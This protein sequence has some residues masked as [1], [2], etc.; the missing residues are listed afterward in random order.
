VKRAAW[1]FVAL[2]TLAPPVVADD[3]EQAKALFLA[4][5]AAYDKHDY[6]A[7]I[8]AFEGAERA[9]PR[10]PI[11]FSLAQAHRRQ[12]YVDGNAEHQHTAI[13]LFREY[14]KAVPSGGRHEDAMRALQELGALAPQHEGTSISINSSGTPNARVALDGAAA[15]DAPLIGSVS[16][17]KHHAVISADGFASEE[18]DVVAVDGNIVA[19]DV[20]L[21]EKLAHVTISGR[22]GA[23]VIVD[24]RPMGETPFAAPLELSPGTHVI[25]ISK[26]GFEGYVRDLDLARGESRRIDA[27]LP[28]SK[29]RVIATGLLITSAVTVVAAAV[30]AGFAGG[31]TATAAGILNDQKTQNI[32]MAQWSTY[33]DDRTA[34]GSWLI[35]SGATFAAAAALAAT[36]LVLFV[37]D[38]PQVTGAPAR[39]ER[40]PKP[41]EHRNEPTEVSIAPLVSP[42]VV[43]AFASVRF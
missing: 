43:G 33:D 19:L 36:G 14:V 10:P 34:R 24:G 25:S 8:R 35:A 7:A 2:V 11:V 23:V 29:Q 17:G 18:R 31:Y 26:N 13:D 37:F 41:I 32:T 22:A 38:K 42:S 1:L 4:G 5:A 12:F 39:D 3:V 30:F 15:V 28:A 27:G 20:P 9:A 6:L 16:P 40:K 21:K